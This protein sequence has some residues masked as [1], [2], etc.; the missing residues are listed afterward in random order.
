MVLPVR[1]GV[2]GEPGPIDQ[3]YLKE[4]CYGARK[5][6]ILRLSKS[7]G[8]EICAGWGL[9]QVL[10]QCCEHPPHSG[11]G[12]CGNDLAE[13]QRVVASDSARRHRL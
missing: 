4:P 2:A 9:R 7:I 6:K 10:L 5:M 11:G 12:T 1:G 8:A 3:Q 13:A